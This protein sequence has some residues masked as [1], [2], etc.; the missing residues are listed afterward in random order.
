[1]KDLR[2]VNFE[3]PNYYS[4]VSDSGHK[5]L[6][7][8]KNFLIFLA[9]CHTIII[10]NKKGEKVY[11]ASSPDELAL[12]N[13]AKYLGFHFINRDDDNNIVI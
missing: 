1:M 13:G 11:N 3:D 2:N 4:H 7:N 9:I 10:E 6:E 12:V 5:N 8:I